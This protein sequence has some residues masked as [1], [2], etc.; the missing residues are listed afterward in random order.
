MSKRRNQEQLVSDSSIRL[1]QLDNL[2]NID[3]NQTESDYGS[4]EEEESEIEQH[5]NFKSSP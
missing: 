4:E 5:S 1:P 3:P 2:Y